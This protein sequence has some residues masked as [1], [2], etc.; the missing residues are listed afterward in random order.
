MRNYDNLPDLEPVSEI[1]AAARLLRL[2]VWII[3]ALTCGLVDLAF[4]GVW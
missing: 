1:C 3:A 2:W 4:G